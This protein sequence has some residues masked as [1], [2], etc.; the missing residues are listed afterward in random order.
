MSLALSYGGRDEMVDVCRRI[1][2]LVQAGQLDPTAIDE[3]V[4]NQ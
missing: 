3:R 2:E 1:A 4:V